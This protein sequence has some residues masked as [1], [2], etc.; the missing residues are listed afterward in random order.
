[1][2]SRKQQKDQKWKE[3]IEVS[4]ESTREQLVKAV[5]DANTRAKHWQDRYEDE[6]RTSSNLRRQLKELKGQHD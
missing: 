3:A 5:S 4:P 1:M 2:R 6:R